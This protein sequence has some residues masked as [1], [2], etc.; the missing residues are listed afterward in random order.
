MFTLNTKVVIPN[1]I[2]V[3]LTVSLLLFGEQ[4]VF[5]QLSSQFLDGGSIPNENAISYTD[6]HNFEGMSG[7]A[8]TMPF[9][10]GGSCVA[11]TVNRFT[12]SYHSNLYIGNNNGSNVLLAWGQNMATYASITASSGS[13]V[14]APTLVP[15]SNYNGIPYEV[16]SSSSGGANGLSAM[17]LRTSTNLYLF[18][19]AANLSGI[20]TLSGFGGA[21]IN[22][23]AS[24]IT[25]K[26]PA[27]VAVT[28]IA[29][30]AVSQ[31]AL[32]LIT[33]AGHVYIM[34]TNSN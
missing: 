20:S 8:Y 30:V 25:S 12:G 6:D 9:V 24:D 26:L 7:I 4:K 2:T 32:A 14:Y 29:Q 1:Y 19:T 5:G 23:A 13:D 22:S 16:R 28:D 21:A 3:L 17:L 11:G 10:T 27:G 15:A 18:G 34:T 31:K 33:N